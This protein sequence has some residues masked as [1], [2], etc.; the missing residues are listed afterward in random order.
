LSVVVRYWKQAICTF[1]A[2][3]FLMCMAVHLFT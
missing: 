1:I 3:V 2:L